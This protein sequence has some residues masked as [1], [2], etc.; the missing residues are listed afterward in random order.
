MRWLLAL[1][2]AVL[3]GQPYVCAA[4][5][6]GCEG[7]LISLDS[8]DLEAKIAESTIAFRGEVV[9]VEP[10]PTDSTVGLPVLSYDQQITFRVLNSWKG[11]YHAEETVSLTVGVVNACAG[12]GCIFPFNMG[13]VILVLSPYAQSYF[14][15]T[16]Q[17]GWHAA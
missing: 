4:L 12:A 16:F 1:G 6:R 11:R 3:G 9:A 17:T 7:P 13:D 8:K 2:I 14:P 10:D 5:T 15:L